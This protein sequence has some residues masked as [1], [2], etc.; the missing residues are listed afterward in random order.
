MELLSTFD[1]I[2]VLILL[3]FS[4][5]FHIDFHM[6]SSGTCIS[7]VLKMH[8]SLH[9]YMYTIQNLIIFNYFRLENL[10]MWQLLTLYLAWEEIYSHQI[11]FRYWNFWAQLYAANLIWF[12][13]WYHELW[14]MFVFFRLVPN[15]IALSW[16][17]LV[18][19]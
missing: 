13:F 8:Q 16:H 11:S 1:A 10:E 6:I 2:T 19:Q 4:L 18:N 17:I 5:V 12:Y 15:N 7:Y 14:R 3:C 9:P